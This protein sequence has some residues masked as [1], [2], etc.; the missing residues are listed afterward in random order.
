M[1]RALVR[2]L[3]GRESEKGLPSSDTTAI[4]RVA[5]TE[6]RCRN[7]QVMAIAAFAFNVFITALCFSGF[8]GVVVVAIWFILLILTL[9]S[10]WCIPPKWHN[11]EC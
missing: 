11:P 4:V 3:F 6:R 10:G 7:R 9:Y 5:D 2:L 1:I 8:A